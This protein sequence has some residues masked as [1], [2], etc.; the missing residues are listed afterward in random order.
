MKL[1]VIIATI[2]K[3][4]DEKLGIIKQYIEEYKMLDLLKEIDFSDRTLL[5]HAVTQK[6]KR[7]TKLFLDYQ[8]DYK[9]SIDR[10]DKYGKTPLHYAVEMNLIE[11]TKMLLDSKTPINVSDKNGK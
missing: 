1:S 7:I 11:I 3:E 2:T 4:E 6:S 9:V 10:A 5:H 8:V